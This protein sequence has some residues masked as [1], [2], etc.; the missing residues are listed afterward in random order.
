MKKL[1]VLGSLLVL[2]AAC[3]NKENTMNEDKNNVK[4]EIVQEEITPEVQQ[5]EAA[6][7]EIDPNVVE[8]KEGEYSAFETEYTNKYSE[9]KI[10]DVRVA[11]YS[12]GIDILMITD[13]EN[14]SQENF[15][16]IAE[17]IVQNF[18]NKF[19][20]SDESEISVSLDFQ[21]TPLDDAKNLFI[22]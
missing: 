6:I 1:L 7:E 14:F 15:Y 17:D 19:G 2:L 22:K 13:D 12:K 20:F 5:K 3:E 16:K 8:M 4:Q 21:P 11:P 10:T 9:E 18:K